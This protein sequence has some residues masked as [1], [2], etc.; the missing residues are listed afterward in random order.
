MIPHGVPSVLADEYLRRAAVIGADAERV[1]GR[2]TDS[3]LNWAPP[4]GGWSV[5]QV[6]EH[7]LLVDSLYLPKMNALVTGS[8]P[9]ASPQ[10]W[11]PSFFGKLMLKA[12]DPANPG[13][14]SSPR[15]FRPGPAPRPG[16][17]AAFLDQ[18]AEYR[19]ILVRGSR[20]D[21]NRLRLSSPV[22]AIIRVNLGDAYA[23]IVQHA[24][25]HV[26]QVRRVVEQGG[27][28]RE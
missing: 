13:K 3:Q 1:A 6:F 4:D 22:A 17:V 25:R 5:G 21:W 16:V 18:L 26:N 12:I 27:F 9:A 19:T 15:I 14:T 2:L 7:L 11:R 8:A 10:P 23:T 24:E 28:P 20:A